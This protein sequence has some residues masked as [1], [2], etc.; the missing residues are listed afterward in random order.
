MCEVMFK[1]P[2]DLTKAKWSVG[3]L[4]KCVHADK[5]V[6]LDAK[7]TKQELKPHRIGHRTFEVLQ[8]FED[9]RSANGNLVNDMP[10]KKITRNGLNVGALQ[11]GKWA[12]GEEGA[13]QKR[14]PPIATTGQSTG[15]AAR[16]P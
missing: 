10:G 3:A 4:N 12:W 2:V 9:E 16:Q 1:E 8:S 7:M 6:W 11:F 5:P 14:E 13:L 15:T